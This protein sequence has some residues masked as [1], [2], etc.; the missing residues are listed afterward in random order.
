MANG[1]HFGNSSSRI[2]KATWGNSPAKKLNYGTSTIYVQPFSWTQGTLP[3][4][5]TSIAVYRDSC[6]YTDISAGTVASGSSVY[7][8]DKVHFVPQVASGYQIVSCNYTEASSYEVT[9]DI[10]CVSITQI[11]VEQ[12][13]WSYTVNIANG[14]AAFQYRID[15]GSW[16]TCT[17]NTTITGIPGNSTLYIQGTGAQTGYTPDTT[18]YTRTLTNAGGSLTL[19]ATRITWSYT[20]NLGTGMT[21]VRYWID[22]QTQHT[23]ISSNTTVTGI[24]F[25]S[26]LHVQGMA[27]S[28]G[29]T[30]NTTQYDRTYSNAGGSITINATRITWT[31]TPTAGNYVDASSISYRFNSTGSWISVTSGTPITADYADTVNIKALAQSEAPYDYGSVSG[32]GSYT[33]SSPTTGNK[34]VELTCTRTV[35][36]FMAEIT[37][38]LNVAGI[39][40]SRTSSP[41]GGG[42]TGVIISNPSRPGTSGR[43]LVY[44]GDV[45]S[46]SATATTGYHFGFS[47]ANTTDTY[48]NTG[49]T[50]D[51]SWSPT[52]TQNSTIVSIDKPIRAYNIRTGVITRFANCTVWLS[53]SSTATSGST[54][55]TYTVGTTVYGFCQVNCLHN[56]VPSDWTLIS[57][58]TYME[59]AIYRTGSYTI[60][61]ADTPDTYDLSAGSAVNLITLVTTKKIFFGYGDDGVYSANPRVGWWAG[62]TPY[63]YGTNL[64]SF[65]SS[66]TLSI[67]TEQYT[68]SPPAQ[69]QGENYYRTITWASSTTN[70]IY[71]SYTNYDQ[72]AITAPIFD[73]WRV[74]VGGTMSQVA[75]SVSSLSSL[76]LSTSYAYFVFKQQNLESTTT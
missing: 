49:V 46:G 3:T 37:R 31:L 50:G 34:Q 7:Y 74:G 57:G 42:S 58:T 61:A 12:S 63:T 11:V 69:F 59:N 60:P 25:A 23:Y 1:I 67:S 6:K 35:K 76:S 33:Y 41:Y 68:S 43:A 40:L 20:I 48:S 4:G 65:S 72:E 14:Q 17:T 45:L 71:Y 15:S 52:V 62:Y 32:I 73:V 70:Y 2:K 13:T 39:A 29:Y 51:I 36:T 64:G 28:T 54:S 24:D 53:T 9:G 19:S 30:P 75:T 21:S 47:N 16:T 44:Y 22:N 8:Q 27:A 5:V 55:G 56:N 66:T 10:N 18:L 38:N 26:T